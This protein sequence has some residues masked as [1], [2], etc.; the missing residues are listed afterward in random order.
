MGSQGLTLSAAC[1]CSLPLR[2]VAF[3]GERCARRG[4]SVARMQGEGEAA[5]LPLRSA[6]VRR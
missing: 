3:R 4:L 2:R 1:F 5:R 6:S